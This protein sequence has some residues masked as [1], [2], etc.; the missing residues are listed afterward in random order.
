MKMIIINQIT[1]RTDIDDGSESV[2]PTVVNA[3]TVRTYYPRKEG[4]HGTR[5]TF[6]DGGGWA[7]TDTPDEIDAM[8]ARVG[9]TFLNVT[10]VQAVAAI[11]D[12]ETG[13]HLNADDEGRTAARVQAEHIRC[14]YPRKDGKVGTRITFAKGSGMAVLELF[15]RV[16]TAC[17]AAP[18]AALPSA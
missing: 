18:Q 8:M 16:A 15:E 17:G 5:I 6:A 10:M 1:G 7:V 4:A 9:V 3:D 13:E 11:I 12:E 14:F 2:T